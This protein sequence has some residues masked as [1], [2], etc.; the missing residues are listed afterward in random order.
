MK[1]NTI[2]SI[3]ARQVLDCKGR[4]TIEVDVISEG[5]IIGR[6]SAP[7]GSSV[8]T[9]EAYVLRD[10]NPSHFLGKSVY[11]AI[12]NIHN[13]IAHALLGMDIMNQ[14]AIDQKMI[15]IDGTTNKCKIGGNAI[16]SISIACIKAAARIMKLPLYKYLYRY[17]SVNNSNKIK[18]IPLPTFNCINGGVYKKFTVPF[19]EYTI[20]PYKA[21]TIF[22][23]VEIGCILFDTIG[24]IIK[25]KQ[26]GNVA[27]VGNYYGWSPPID[28]PKSILLILKEATIRCGVANKVGF[29]LDC[30][31]NEMYNSK[32]KTY[33]F[34]N[35]EIDSDEMIGVLK[36]LTKEFNI[37]YIED[38]LEENDWEG[39]QKAARI[40][41]DTIIVGDDLTVTN[42]E[43]LKKAYKMNAIKGF[44]FKPNQVGTVT[45]SIEAYEYANNK[46]IVVI[47]SIR[48]GGVID[49]IVIDMAV[50]LGTP[51]LKNGA[52]RTGERIYAINSLLRIS[53]ENPHATPFEFTKF[54]DFNKTNKNINH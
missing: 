3:H 15:D 32:R 27:E 43:R 31:C 11:K 29:A 49:D 22:E 48:A 37:L 34:M 16:Y 40:L 33:Y 7:T 12:D 47:P 6:G 14:K 26:G 41:N 23:A 24:E 50:A 5:G 20:V 52:P 17:I 10:N 44:I 28:D 13:I 42:L 53:E 54:I 19:Q 2:S 21:K 9:H 18:Y 25:E 35:K 38:P 45:E 8:G 36:E 46:K 30:A 51:F 4:P 1:K 39:W